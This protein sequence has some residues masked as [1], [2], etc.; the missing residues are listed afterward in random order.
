[1]KFVRY[2]I[3]IILVIVLILVIRRQIKENHANSYDPILWTLKEI[4]K[5]VDPIISKLKL[6]RGQKSYTIN[7]E[8]V[9]LCLYDEQGEYYPINMLIYVLLH[10]VAHML[11]NIDIG[12]TKNFNRKFDELLSK[13]SEIGVYNP[14]IPIILNYCNT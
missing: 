5:P 6:Y 3:V 4:L 7:K 12:H 9:Y 14:S 2:F 8:K 1:M 11:N 13:A 10:E